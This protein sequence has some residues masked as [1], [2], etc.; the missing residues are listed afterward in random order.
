LSGSPAPWFLARVKKLSAAL[1]VVGLFVGVVLMIARSAKPATPP[2]AASAEAI[3]PVPVVEP[4]ALLEAW[5]KGLPRAGQWRHGF[6]VVD[7]DGDGQLDIVH[8]PARKS[9]TRVPQI[10]AGDGKGNFTLLTR[11]TFPSVAF[12]YGDVAVADFDGDAALD[13]ALA[14]HLQGI[15][16]LLRRGD[17]FETTGY[18]LGLVHDTSKEAKR[19][20]PKN[21]VMKGFSSRAIAALDWNLDGR[22]D[23][24]AESDGPRPFEAIQGKPQPRPSLAVLLGTPAGFEP[25]FPATD[26]PGHGDSLVIAELDP[27]PGLE[28]LAAANVVGSKNLMYRS[29][30]A[31]LVLGELPGAPDGRVVRVVAALPPRDGQT[32]VL[33]GGLASGERGLA[34][35]LDLVTIG[36]PSG[37]GSSIPLFHGEPQRAVTAIGVGDLEGDGR[38][39]VMFGDEQGLLRVLASKNG[40]LDQIGQVPAPSQLVGCAVYGIVFSNLDGQPGDEIVVS[41]AGDDGACASSGAIEVYRRAAK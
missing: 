29:T 3:A 32:Q 17:G 37:A 4:V 1:F 2:P 16:V 41:Y 10:F 6:V 13:I 14:S 25:L 11:Y 15:A 19:P 30:D 20:A 9:P 21:P 18:E 26:V 5:G 34:G 24:I 35:S 12:E 8:G 40:S 39:D 22:M 36:A 31:G 38:A 33:L 7:F 23:L 27:A 28:V